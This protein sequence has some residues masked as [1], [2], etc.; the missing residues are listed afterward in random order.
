MTTYTIHSMYCSLSNLW[1]WSDQLI[2]LI[3][4]ST[5]CIQDLMGDVNDTGCILLK[6]KDI[7]TAWPRGEI[8]NLLA[9]FEVSVFTKFSEELLEITHMLTL[10]QAAQPQSCF[11]N[12]TTLGVVCDESG[13]RDALFALSDVPMHLASSFGQIFPLVDEYGEGNVTIY[14]SCCELPCKGGMN[15]YH[16][17]IIMHMNIIKIMYTLLFTYSMTGFNLIH[18]IAG[19]VSVIVILILVIVIAICCC[20]VCYYRSHNSSKP[21][22]VLFQGHSYNDRIIFIVCMASKQ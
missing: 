8:A 17:A 1:W 11:T 15:A 9:P 6:Y 14:F 4:R 10:N 19:S 16:D 18:A 22:W 5:Y 3:H 7:I 20:V 13:C 12:C 2:M 21:M